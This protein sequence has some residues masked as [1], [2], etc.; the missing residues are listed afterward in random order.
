MIINQLNF[1]KLI[2][3]PEILLKI[4]RNEKFFPMHMIVS[5]TNFCNHKCIWC[6][7]YEYQKGEALFF[8]TQ[9]LLNFIEKA[10]QLGLK[11]I[12]YV[13][14]GEPTLHPD[15]GLLTSEINKMGV[16]QG[17]FTNG[18]KI[19]AFQEHYLKYFSFVRFSLDAYD[20]ESHF[21]THGVKGQFESI[22]E[23]IRDLLVLRRMDGPQ[24][25]AQFVF[26]NYNYEGIEEIAKISKEIGLDYISYKPAFNR[27][28]IKERGEKNTLTL[29]DLTA[30]IAAAKETMEDENFRIFFREFQIKSLEKNILKS[31]QCYGG[32]FSLLLYED[33]SIVVCG[34]NHVV[35]GTIQDSPGDIVESVYKIVPKIDVK[36]CPA[37]C[38]YHPL[39]RLI[40]LY[41]N[42]AERRYF[43]EFFI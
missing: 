40:H 1:E 31:D 6:T 32:L 9:N 35:A 12:T 4:K 43:N 17:I 37:G 18:T 3:N 27:G 34:P 5:L 29:S 23:Q 10:A 19:K 41:M 2:F 30:R 38:R 33:E 14:N 11:A 39:N 13:G 25:G 24:I 28:A 21:K 15:F 22:I 8:N 7:V 20:N 26:H 36:K 42:P 16:E